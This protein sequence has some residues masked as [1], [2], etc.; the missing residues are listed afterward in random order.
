MALVDVTRGLPFHSEKHLVVEFVWFW[1]YQHFLSLIG[2]FDGFI[3]KH[4]PN[5]LYI[6]HLSF[7]T[8]RIT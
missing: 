5:I 1:R 6:F 8:A 4:L 2:G 3:G 7:S